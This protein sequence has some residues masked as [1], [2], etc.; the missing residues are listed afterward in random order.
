MSDQVGKVDREKPLAWIEVFY[1]RGV[2]KSWDPGLNTRIVGGPVRHRVVHQ[3][4]IVHPTVD[5][6]YRDDK[7]KELFGC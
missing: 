6:L 7:T 5:H 3:L 2:S 4:H 1:S